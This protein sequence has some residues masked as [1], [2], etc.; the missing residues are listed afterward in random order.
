MTGRRLL[1]TVASFA[2]IYL[3][4]GSTYLAI[5]YAIDTI[6]PF[7]MAGSRFA[8]AGLPLLLYGWLRGAE[9]PSKAQ[10]KNASLVG[11]L[12]F[13][14]GNGFVTWA[15]ELVPSGLAAVLIA[16]VPI[17]M[18]LFHRILFNGPAFNTRTI[19]G[20]V[21]GVLGVLVLVNPLGAA[22]HTIHPLGAGLLLFSAVSWALGSHL[23]QR[24]ELPK[25][26]MMSVGAEMLSG[27]VILTVAGLLTGEAERFHFSEVTV[28]SAASFFYLVLFGSIVAFSAY[29]YLLRHTSPAAASTYAFVN[30][31]VAVLLGWLF[32]NETLSSRAIAASTLIVGAVVLIQLRKIKIPFRFR[33]APE[34]ALKPTGTQ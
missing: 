12:L 14:G 1:L 20:L 5:R 26:P 15:E 25:S 31:V 29:L 34:A 30:P 27:G 2:S 17:W 3:I 19:L 22:G 24:L 16:L 4:W 21:L 11:G 7:L 13:L 32:G 8:L 28:L 9:L 10:W 18:V 33:I 23:S 6:P